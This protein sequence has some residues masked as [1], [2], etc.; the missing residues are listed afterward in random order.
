MK[1][2]LRQEIKNAKEVYEED[3]RV[4]RVIASFN[5]IMFDN[6]TSAEQRLQDFIVYAD[7]GDN[8]RIKSK[9]NRY[10][11]L[12]E[13]EIYHRFGKDFT[14]INYVEKLREILGFD[15]LDITDPSELKKKIV[16]HP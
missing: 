4:E 9:S 2:D 11:F 12:I 13:K 3:T 14:R 1:L 5:K 10:Q 8:F 15:F 7:D 6:L 16:I